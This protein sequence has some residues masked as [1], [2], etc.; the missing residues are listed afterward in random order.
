[1]ESTTP[2]S[3]KV[4]STN[5][6]NPIVILASINNNTIQSDSSGTTQSEKT[7]T[8]NHKTRLKQTVS[9]HAINKN[10]KPKT[11]NS[12]QGNMSPKSPRPSAGA[13]LEQTKR[14]KRKRRAPR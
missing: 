2:S 11:T 12:A 6:D 3:S 8:V 7:S 14:K 10:E 5:N 13:V 9:N 4:H 1:M